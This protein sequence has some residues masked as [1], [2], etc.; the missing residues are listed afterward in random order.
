[1]MNTLMSSPK[2][3]YKKPAG[4][5]YT[6]ES[7]LPCDEYTGLSLLLGAFVIRSFFVN[8]F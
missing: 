1:M 6:R 8:L 5:K 2:L 4:A 7:R 3:V